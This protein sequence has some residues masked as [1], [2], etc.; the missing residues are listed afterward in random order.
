VIKRVAYVLTGALLGVAQAPAAEPQMPESFQGIW[1]YSTGTLGFHGPSSYYP[2]PCPEEAPDPNQ[3]EITATKVNDPSIPLSCIVHQVIKFDVC[4]WG[5]RYRNRA[6]AR[7]LRSF[8]I[9]PWGPGYHIVLQCASAP[10]RSETVGT[11][12]LIEKGAISVGD[13]PRHYRC[14]RDRRGAR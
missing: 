14:P 13:V 8:Q 1:C 4:P 6:Q 12:W 11:D 10:K 2:G 5:M 3:I 7:A 9:N